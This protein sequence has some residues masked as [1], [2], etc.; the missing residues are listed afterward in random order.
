M[1]FTK[2]FELF[3]SSI[4]LGGDIHFLN[5]FNPE[6]ID[7]LKHYN[8]ESAIMIKDTGKRN[9]DQQILFANNSLNDNIGLYGGAINIQCS[10]S[11]RI[12]IVMKD[13]QY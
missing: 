2:R 7:I 9:E 4:E 11:S 6:K 5:Y 13:N 1:E 8:V 10:D 3:D 12:P